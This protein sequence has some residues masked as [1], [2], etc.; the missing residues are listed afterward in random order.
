L[1]FFEKMSEALPLEPV[2]PL[3]C[4]FSAVTTV[5]ERSVGT[6][7]AG[8]WAN[9][10]SDMNAVESKKIYFLCREFKHHHM[11]RTRSLVA[12]SNE[13]YRFLTI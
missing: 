7:R 4:F 13:A 2:C 8:G 10:R 11:V 3:L 5:E 9:P 1:V 6:C 12:V